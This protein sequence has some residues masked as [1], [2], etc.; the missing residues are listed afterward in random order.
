MSSTRLNDGRVDS[1][2][3]NFSQF[4]EKDLTKEAQVHSGNRIDNY[5]D[6]VNGAPH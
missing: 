2:F 6:V 4:W 1:N 3:E 5:T